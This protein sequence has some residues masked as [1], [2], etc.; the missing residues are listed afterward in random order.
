MATF[1]GVPRGGNATEKFFWLFQFVTYRAKAD[2]P[3]FRRAGSSGANV[4]V[5][6][7]FRYAVYGFKGFFRRSRFVHCRILELELKASTRKLAMC[8]ET[9]FRWKGRHLVKSWTVG[10]ILCAI[11]LCLTSYFQ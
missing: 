11:N 7:C 3:A 1:G 4:C 6:D 2:S 8:F 9:D 10:R 5:F